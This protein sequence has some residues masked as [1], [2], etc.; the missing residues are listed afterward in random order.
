[1]ATTLTPH[2]YSRDR[3]LGVDGSLTP[4]RCVGGGHPF[5]AWGA[6]SLTDEP[7]G[8]G[9]ESC[10]STSNVLQQSQQMVRDGAADRVLRSCHVRRFVLAMVN[11]AV[12]IWVS[13]AEGPPGEGQLGGGLGH[14]ATNTT[15]LRARGYYRRLRH[16]LRLPPTHVRPRV[17]RS[18]DGCSR[19]TPPSR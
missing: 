4:F 1:M 16:L 13:Q 11:Q 12:R 10:R 17:A 2:P 9:V 14:G 18:C 15:Q 6:D 3:Q 19:S 8:A 7:C 5:D